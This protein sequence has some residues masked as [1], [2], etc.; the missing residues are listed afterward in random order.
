MAIRSITFNKGFQITLT[1]PRGVRGT[2]L[3]AVPRGFGPL[4]DEEILDI[5]DDLAAL[6]RMS[7]FA[8]KA[9]IGAIQFS[10]T[11]KSLAARWIDIWYCDYDAAGD[12]VEHRL[13]GSFFN[14]DCRV[15]HKIRY[16]RVSEAC[17]GVIITVANYSSFTIEAEG[18]GYS[19]NGKNFAIPLELP[20]GADVEL[21]QF[22]V[23]V[24]A[25]VKMYSFD[26]KYPARFLPLMR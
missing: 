22:E 8:C 12:R 21:P 1:W 24:D 7:A 10:P 15:G 18:I 3:Y 20:R 13:A 9:G 11:D 16:M 26:D 25:D 14:G 17:N 4:T 5:R 2:V 19:V 23:P 6:E